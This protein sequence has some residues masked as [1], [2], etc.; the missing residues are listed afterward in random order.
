MNKYEHPAEKFDSARKYLERSHSEGDVILIADAFRECR[1]AL[2][3]LS[4]PNVDYLDDGVKVTLEQLK[5][6]MDTTGLEDQSESSLDIVKAELLTP[7][8][9]VELS[10]VV[11]YLANWF[12]TKS[13]E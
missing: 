3:Q 9:K 10:G 5:E 6:L 8:Q 7:D 12:D 1:S 11:N 13:S 4:K 2:F